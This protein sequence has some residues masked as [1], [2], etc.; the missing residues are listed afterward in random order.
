MTNIHM[1]SIQPIRARRR[2]TAGRSSA[3]R[4]GLEMST[5]WPA[6]DVALVSV[7]GEIDAASGADLLDYALSKALLCRL[8]ILNLERVRFLSCS[9][10]RTIRTLE[11]RCA[12]A[13]VELSVLYGSSATRVLQICDTA[14]Q[15]AS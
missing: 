14:H 8:L 9:G 13:D 15:R 12:M 10:Y 6:F 1:E 11:R 2:P 3:A 4:P 7:E 5:Q